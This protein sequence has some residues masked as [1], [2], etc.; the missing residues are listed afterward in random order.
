MRLWDSRLHRGAVPH[1]VGS[2]ARLAGRVLAPAAVAVVAVVVI[3]AVSIWSEFTTVAP[4]TSV[5]EVVG[6]LRPSAAAPASLGWAIEHDQRVNILWLAHGGAGHDNPNFT[7]TILVLSIRPAT[8]QT[9][10]VALPRFL[11]VDMPALAHGGVSGKLYSAF[12]LGAQRDNP[13]LRPQ[14]RTATGSGDL[15]AAT[16]AGV[17]GEPIAGWAAIDTTAFREVVDALGGIRINVPT[18]LDD[19]V[20]PVDDRG[21]TM[22][23]HFN[24]GPQE[25]NGE[26]ALEYARSRL[27]TSD[28]DRSSR[29]VLV[30]SALLDR[31]R[32]VHIGPVLVRLLGALNDG[33]LTNLRPN[34]MRQ[35]SRLL[36]RVR[37]AN[38]SHV[39]V[40]ETNVLRRQPMA[41]GDYILV[42]AD[43]K[44]VDVQRYVRAAL[45]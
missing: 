18:S 32:T 6:L 2:G 39:S 45:P 17:I 27:S 15:A 13:G 16:V 42:P 8:G 23:I 44:L 1:G 43:G 3:G 12:A 20:Y 41:E 9:T 40:D 34:E 33:A 22:H 7:D 19:P 24:R 30:M 38:L 21:R 4:R 11:W 36:A 35:L 29:Q 5:A 10:V 31:L 28:S 25:M 26:R 37:L 14:W